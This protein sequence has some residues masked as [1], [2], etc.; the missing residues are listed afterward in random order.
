MR[1]C[2][3]FSRSSFPQSPFTLS[4]AE[5]R[6]V[7]GIL[8][9][10]HVCTVPGFKGLVLE[11][12]GLGLGLQFAICSST[13]S[14]VLDLVETAWRVS[15]GWESLA[16]QTTTASTATVTINL[17]RDYSGGFRAPLPRAEALSLNLDGKCITE[18]IIKIRIMKQILYFEFYSFHVCM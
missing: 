9:I 7:L 5:E 17:A 4:L 18:S 8:A 10:F 12:Q 14:Y 3:V 11:S 15:N 2:T 13:C 16:E 6:R 1:S